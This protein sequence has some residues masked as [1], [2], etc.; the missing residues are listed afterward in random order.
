MY[1]YKD[2]SSEECRMEMATNIESDG[3]SDFFKMWMTCTVA[4]ST[5]SDIRDSRHMGHMIFAVPQ[6]FVCYKGLNTFTAVNK[7]VL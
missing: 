3:H 6:P 5:N 4:V 7:N 2:N 1:F